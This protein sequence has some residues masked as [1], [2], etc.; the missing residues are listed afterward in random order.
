MSK[1][2]ENTEK[3]AKQLAD[4]ITAFIDYSELEG[5]IRNLFNSKEMKELIDFTS[6]TILKYFKILF[7]DKKIEILLSSLVNYG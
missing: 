1:N 2:Q 3:V 6:E 4:L 7:P 5:L